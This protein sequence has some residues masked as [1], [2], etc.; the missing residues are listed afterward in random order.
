LRKRRDIISWK[1]QKSKTNEA[2]YIELYRKEIKSFQYKIESI[3][4]I[5]GKKQSYNNNANI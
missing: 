5:N 1:I 3:I 2:T 4:E